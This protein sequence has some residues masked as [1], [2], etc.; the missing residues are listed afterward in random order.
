MYVIRHHAPFEQAVALAIEVQQSRL[1]DFRM[2]GFTQQTAPMPRILIAG[3]QP[4]ELLF[5][6][7]IVEFTSFQI[8]L[9]SK[10]HICGHGIRQTESQCLN[11]AGGIQMR[12]V[13]P[14]MPAF[15]P[16]WLIH[17]RI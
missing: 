14:R 8:P 7:L 3:N 13:S 6:F 5:T 4:V 9:P 10:D 1:H 11:L 12:Q 17:T 16:K 2:R 15:V